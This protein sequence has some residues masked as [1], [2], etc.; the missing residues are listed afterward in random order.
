MCTQRFTAT[1]SWE[2]EPAGGAEP[3]TWG[4]LTIALDD[5]LLWGTHEGTRSRGVRWTWV[6]LLEHLAE[7][8]PWLLL[9]EGWPAGPTI[10]S[11][12][13]VPSDTRAWLEGL[14][15]EEALTK[16]DELFE[17]RFRHDLAM[18]IRGKVLPPL[19]IVREGQHAWVGGET[20]SAR[21]D[22]DE[23]EAVLRSLGDEI[24]ERLSRLEDE[25]AREA[26][27]SWVSRSLGTPEPRHHPPEPSAA[28]FI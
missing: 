16:E 12:T 5:V 28:M 14:P 2:A 15:A 11:P 25:R 8:W 21:L 9:E 26:V 23:V 22:V 17:H 27:C 4:E 1:L 20:T 10:A 24:A 7:V 3:G 13:S 18:A 19:W 6:D